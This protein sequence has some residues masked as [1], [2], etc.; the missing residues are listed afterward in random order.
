MTHATK[1]YSLIV[2]LMFVGLGLRLMHFS[3]TT[4]AYDQARDAFQ[5]LEIMSTDPIKIIGPTTDI[6]G[7]FHGS[8]YWYI[9]SVPYALSQGNPLA[10]KLVM[11]LLHL[12]NIPLIYIIS[13]KLT[14]NHLLAGL[15]AMLMAFSFDAISYARWLSNPTLATLSIAG[16][17]YGLWLSFHKKSIGAGL[18][19]VM[20]AL[21]VQFQ[22]FL[23]YLMPFMF[24]G[25]Y[26]LAKDLGVKHLFNVKNILLACIGG[27]FLAPFVISEVKFGFQGT[28]S[29]LQFF[30]T[31]NHTRSDFSLIGKEILFLDRLAGNAF[32]SI[33]GIHLNLSLIHI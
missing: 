14:R 18:M 17:F 28:R 33:I 7:L 6:S 16:F 26:R 20:W 25:W 32:Y 5:A 4:F 9:I 12:F 29:L 1:V 31:N 21:C 11:I 3:H 2:I 13:Y 8:L 19:L 22:F 30:F 27:V 23:L 24:V 10:V 15:A